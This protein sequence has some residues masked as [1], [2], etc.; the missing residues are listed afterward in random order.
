MLFATLVLITVNRKHDGLEERVD[1]GHRN[2]PAEVRNMPRFR[3]QEE[4]K[5]AVL[6][7]LIVVREYAFLDIGGI[8]EV[9]RYLV[10]L[11]GD[12]S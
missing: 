11:D 10:L 12:T 2:K 7:G 6:L 3:L 1:F 4:Q 9:A 8:F 5:V